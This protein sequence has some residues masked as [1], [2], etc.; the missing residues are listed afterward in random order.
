MS[1]PQEEETMTAHRLAALD[2]NIAQ[3]EHKWRDELAY[4]SVR[5]DAP[6]PVRR[7]IRGHI[8]P[9]PFGHK[10]RCSPAQFRRSR[11]VVPITPEQSRSRWITSSAWGIVGSADL[12]VNFPHVVQENGSPS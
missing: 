5:G 1:L 9:A 2:A 10:P 4:P 7:D 12:D 11:A 6:V 3:L 8:R